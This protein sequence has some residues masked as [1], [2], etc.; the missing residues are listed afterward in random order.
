MASMFMEMDRVKVSPQMNVVRDSE[1]KER[2]ENEL[3]KSEREN[4]LIV[5]L[6]EKHLQIGR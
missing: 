1:K 3:R 5:L 2:Q 4:T 6:P